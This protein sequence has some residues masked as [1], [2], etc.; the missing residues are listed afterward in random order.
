VIQET[1]ED[2]KGQ[3]ITLTGI[4]TAYSYQKEK[5]RALEHYKQARMLQQAM[6]DR[7]GQALTLKNI[8]DVYSEFGELREGL[9]YY[10]QALRLLQAI[11]NRRIEAYTLNNIGRVY[12]DLGEKQKALECYQQALPLFG[13]VSDRSGEAA[14]L[15]NLMYY[16]KSSN[17]HLAIFYGKQSVNLLQQARSMI[18][19]LDRETQKSFL[20]SVEGVY[21]LLTDLLIT[22]GRLSEAHQALNLSKDQEYFDF[23]GIPGRKNAPAP[24][25]LGLTSLERVAEHRY[26]QASEKVVSLDRQ[27]A[28][29]RLRFNSGDLDTAEQQQLARLEADIKIATDQLT[30]L[31]KQ[32][33]TEFRA[34]PSSSD[35]PEQI[36]DTVE[37]QHALRELSKS[38]GSRSVAIYTVITVENCRVLLITPDK[39]TSASPANPIKAVDLNMKA[40]EL[41]RRLQNP[42]LNPRPVARELHDALFKPIETELRKAR[43]QTLMWSL[44]LSLRYLP[45]AALYDGKKYLIERFNIVVFTRSDK[46]RMTAEVSPTWTG[47][48]FGSSKEQTVQVAGR[49]FRFNALKAVNRELDNIFGSQQSQTRGVLSGIV[50]RD[51][52]FTK[53]EML[54]AFA[55]QRRPLAHIASHFRFQPG[56]DA[57]SFLL[58]G[59]GEVMTLAE[60]KEAADDLFRGVELLGSLGIAAKRPYI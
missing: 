44:D 20:K 36:E 16:W 37:L 31:H 19:G 54:K 9:E 56:N 35:K 41:L 18:L 22:K 38:T 49:T 3:A 4:G 15:S 39:I 46:A 52:S 1:I 14:T 8:G 55:E 11:S 50:R 47:L 32:F 53:V 28:E 17:T 26:Q 10:L 2:P 23:V 51:E 58:L 48:G 42:S 25:R 40:L 29:L 60:M 6:G 30:A 7:K 45:M 59:N 13:A 12:D 57:E 5:L 43:A 33:D 21:R 24:R 34:S 27:Y